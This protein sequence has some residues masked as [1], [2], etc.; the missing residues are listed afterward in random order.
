[1]TL[2]GPVRTR[3][4]GNTAFLSITDET[5]SPYKP[6][7]N[8]L[9]LSRSASTLKYRSSSITSRPS[10]SPQRPNLSQ[11]RLIKGSDP[12]PRT[13]SIFTRPLQLLSHIYD[14]L[15]IHKPSR[16]L[17]KPPKP[18]HPPFTHQP[19]PTYLNQS[20]RQSSLS[21]HASPS[22]NMPVTQSLHL[23]EF[24]QLK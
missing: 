20:G 9:A 19:I 24:G 11:T 1:M 14:A 8:L 18:Q 16:Y 3:P 2:L 21:S 12:N 17:T 13:Q 10:A 4:M 7:T 6:H 15:S 22:V 23:G 5:I